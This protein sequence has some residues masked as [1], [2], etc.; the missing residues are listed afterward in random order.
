MLPHYNAR[1]NCTVSLLFANTPL[2]V[3]LVIGFK[4]SCD[5]LRVVKRDYS[6][7]KLTERQPPRKRNICIM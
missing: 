7:V 6:F 3:L 4:D 2:L 5:P 1:K